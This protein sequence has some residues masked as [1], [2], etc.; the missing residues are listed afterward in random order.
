MTKVQ[1]IYDGKIS[2]AAWV[3]KIFYKIKINY[4][5]K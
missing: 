2:M 3:F 4:V 5:N 1:I